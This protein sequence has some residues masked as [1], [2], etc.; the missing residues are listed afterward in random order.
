MSMQDLPEMHTAGGRKPPIGCRSFIEMREKDLLYVDKTRFIKTLMRWRTKEDLFLRPQGFG[1]SVNLSMLDAY[2]NMEYK[3]RAEKWFEGLEITRLRPNDP[4]MNSYPVIFLDFTEINGDS[5][6]EIVD[7]FGRY[8]MR[9]FGRFEYLLD[10]EILSS[11]RRAVFE[12]YLDGTVENHRLIFAIDQL[13][14]MLGEHHGKGVVVLADDYDRLSCTSFEKPHHD[15]LTCFV[16]DM[17][18]TVL[19]SNPFLEY[20]VVTSVTMLPP[21][22]YFYE[23]DKLYA[24]TIQDFRFAE[25]F[26]FTS[27]EVGGI[28]EETGHPE[29]FDEVREWYGGYLFGEVEVY[30]PRGVMEYV[31]YGF[32]NETDL[33]GNNRRYRRKRKD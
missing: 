24:D 2:F 17:L 31:G 14:R 29:R 25:M 8:V 33:G 26:G 13:C 3:G 6:S 5:Y 18:T 20:A 21:A 22:G 19:G 32:H 30:N 27:D 7:S 28:L 23:L 10:S 1:K 4:K 9:L 16:T 12:Q 11:R 15:E